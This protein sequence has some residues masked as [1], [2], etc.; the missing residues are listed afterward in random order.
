[1][2]SKSLIKRGLYKGNKLLLLKV[3]KQLYFKCYTFKKFFFAVTTVSQLVFLAGCVEQSSSRPPP[4]TVIQSDASG[5][6]A[7]R[8]SFNLFLNDLEGSFRNAPRVGASYEFLADDGPNRDRPLGDSATPDQ[9]AVRVRQL[10]VAAKTAQKRGDYETSLRLLR[11]AVKLQKSAVIGFQASYIYLSLGKEE[12]RF[13]NVS[14]GLQHLSTAESLA[15]PTGNSDITY[16]EVARARLAH[17]LGR[18]EMIEG[19]LKSLNDW[20]VEVVR[21][22]IDDPRFWR[23]RRA[24]IRTGEAYLELINGRAL[25]AIKRF[26]DANSDYREI[27]ASTLSRG[28]AGA[29]GIGAP[30]YEPASL[31]LDSVIE[32]RAAI[33]ETYQKIGDLGNAEVEI[34]GALNEL[35][36][37]SS[38]VSAQSLELVAL[39]GE[40]LSEQGRFLQSKRLLE[41]AQIGLSRLEAAPNNPARIRVEIELAAVHVAQGETAEALAIYDKINR[42]IGESGDLRKI[43]FDGSVRYGLALFEHRRFDEAKVQFKRRMEMLS[44][45]NA[46]AS[47]AYA[48]AAAL[49]ALASAEQSGAT[50]ETEETLSAA[51]PR[52]LRPSASGAGDVSVLFRE[53]LRKRILE[54]AIEYYANSGRLTDSQTLRNKLFEIADAARLSSVDNALLAYSSRYIPGASE[55]GQL[56]RHSQDLSNQYAVQSA[57]LANAI[58]QNE[59]AASIARLRGVVAGLAEEL[60][61]ARRRIQVTAPEFASVSSPQ[62][63]RVDTVAQSLRNGERLVSVY[64]SRVAT[65]VWVL[66][67][68]GVT[69]FHRSVEANSASLLELAKRARKTVELEVTNIDEIPDFD[70][71][72]AYEIFRRVLK[73]IEQALGPDGSTLLIVP[74]WTIASLPLQMLLTEPSILPPNSGVPFSN[75]ASLPYLVK[76]YSVAQLPSAS[77]LVQL[78]SAQRHTPAVE[79]FIGFGDPF[80]NERQLAQGSAAAAPRVAPQAAAIVRGTLSR[81]S[82]R[83]D[84]D[85]SEVD[86]RKVDE[87]SLSGLIRLPETRDEV[88]EIAS[89]L[90][91]DLRRD[92]YVG[93]AANEQSVRSADLSRKQVVMFAT[94]GLMAGDL[95]GLNEPALAMTAPRLAGVAGDGILT[96]SDVMA[97]KLNADWIILSAC[98]TGASEAQGAEAM[99]GLGRAFFYAGA[100]S[101]LLTNWAVESTSAQS[102]TTSTFRRKVNHPHETRAEA[103]RNA[104]LE[105]MGQGLRDSRTS[106][107]VMSYAH[108]TFWASY[109]LFGDPSL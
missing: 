21:G 99:S 17:K 25:E 100:R 78:R 36:K 6:G 7:V 47:S 29:Q 22:R 91:A 1:M 65:Y 4:V 85:G 28:D 18:R 96:S 32:N 101:I 109:T 56:I 103:F 57:M 72:S 77:A 40:L 31:Y 39:L 92:V 23:N 75:H 3:L 34:L 62:A 44:G 76:K 24:A 16:I 46:E 102:I 68:T 107:F 41:I 79:P 70:V 35:I 49:Y 27:H 95:P 15:R 12:L 90:G 50:P 45:D 69:A 81:R 9:I 66:D 2:I 13:G 48:R 108:P 84:V 80:F 61:S 55:L 98:N 82:V 10:D 106:D 30:W 59:A 20:R 63:G 73:P 89:I 86:F 58:A 64:T 11:D 5:L 94:H 105:V 97:L 43:F 54:Q 51:I 88:I 38:T 26:R 71:K 42:A 14:D 33:A 87:R 8:Q 19:S 67:T 93:V 83:I 37:H 53:R 60:T 104:L 52:L 74:D